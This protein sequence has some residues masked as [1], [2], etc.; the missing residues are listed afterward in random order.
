MFLPGTYGTS[1]LRKHALGGVLSAMREEGI[2]DAVS[3]SLA[4]MLDC[5]L[6]FFGDAVASPI[7]Y[8]ILTGTVFVLVLAYI[9]MNKFKKKA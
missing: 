1:L 3:D 7:M 8:S 9:L 5:N 6:Y 4:D 2:P